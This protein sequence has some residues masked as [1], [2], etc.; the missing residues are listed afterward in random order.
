MTTLEEPTHA[1]LPDHGPRGVVH[2]MR[3][4]D[5]RARICEV[6]ATLDA[7]ELDGRPLILSSPADGPM[8]FYRGAIVAPWPNRIGDGTYTW[9]GIEHR[10]ALSEPERGNALHGLVS[11]QRFTPVRDASAE[12]DASRSAL[13]LRT[14]LFP[15]TGYPFHLVLDVD[16]VLDA[17]AGLTTTV[18]AHN[19][20]AQDAPYGVCPHPYLVA[21]PEPLDTWVLDLDAATV[22]EV[23]PDRLLP[24]GT[25]P[26]TEG[27]LLDLA[28]GCV[29]GTAQLDHAV[30]DL[31]RADGIARVTVTA[32]GGTGVEIAF[33][34]RCPWVQVYTGDRPEPEN[35]RKGLAVEPMTCPPDAFR[36]GTDVVRLRPGT[37]HEA[38][39]TLR[40]L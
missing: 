37:S 10:T 4:G 22:L 35:H 15:V 25:V 11:F 2:E 40:G 13:T 32:P 28:G 9:D 8:L 23:T 20:G 33:D 5:Y 29:I 19:V 12:S 30:T 27:S 31:A 6:G 39:W 17:E 21:G 1:P 18:S 38:S 26:I 24:T 36:T 3:A 14:E 16:Y 7:L 34:E